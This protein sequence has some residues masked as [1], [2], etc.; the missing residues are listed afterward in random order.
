[1]GGITIL[2]RNQAVQT[3][4]AQKVAA[5][6]SDKLGA[7]VN[8]KKLA[9]DFS[10]NI[11][12][13]DILIRDQTGDTMIFSHLFKTQLSSWD[14]N[15]QLVFFNHSSL[16]EGQ[17]NIVLLKDKEDLN[18]R[19]FLDFFKPSNKKKK[20]NKKDW[21]IN[22]KTANLNQVLFTY[23]NQN[24]PKEPSGT[25]DPQ[26]LEF[27]NINGLGK[28]LWLIADSIHFIA[29]DL[30]TVEKSGLKIQSFNAI[31][32]IHNKGMD[33]DELLC[34]TECSILQ[35]ELHFRYPGYKLLSD[36]ISNTEWK[37]KLRNTSICLKE[38][39]IFS[40]F[41]KNNTETLNLNSNISGT[42]DNLNLTKF[43]GTI[44]TNT[45]IKGDFSFKGLPKIYQSEQDFNIKEL[46][47]NGSD[48]SAIIGSA[49][50]KTLFDLGQIKYAGKFNGRFLN[51]T[52]SGLFET[53]H[54]NIDIKSLSMDIENGLETGT[55]AGD[56]KTEGFNLNAIVPDKG[57]GII[58]FTGN[59]NGT[60]ITSDIVLEV[61]GNIDKLEYKKGSYQN[62]KVNG[63]ASSKSF[64]G[65]VLSDDPNLNLN[66]DGELG[67]G[68]DNPNW[69]FKTKLQGLDL[70][71]LG[72]GYLGQKVWGLADV[73][74]LGKDIKTLT[75]DILLE[76][77]QIL[78]KGKYYNYKSIAI[79]KT[80]LKDGGSKLE[81]Y[82]DLAEAEIKGNIDITKIGDIIQHNLHQIFPDRFE[83]VP[84]SRDA[85]FSF[86]TDIKKPAFFESFIGEKISTNGITASGTFIES[87]G[88]LLLKTN[89]FTLNYNDININN[90]SIDINKLSPKS[91]EYGIN[92]YDISQAGKMIIKSAEI[93]G[94]AQNGKTSL[95][96]RIV[97]KTGANQVELMGAATLLN[98][99]IPIIINKMKVQIAEKSW[100]LYDM[101]H[102]YYARNRVYSHDLF[103]EGDDNYLEIS[104]FFGS[105]PADTGIIDFSN[106]GP[107][108]FKPFVADQAIL[109]STNFRLS[110]RLLIQSA[111]GNPQIFGETYAK[112]ISYLGTNYGD[113]RID[114]DDAIA[115]NEI[116]LIA[117]GTKGLLE[118]L[119][120]SGTINPS[121]VEGSMF[122]LSLAIPKRTP[123]S[124]IQPILKGI[125]T[126]DSGHISGW[127]KLRGNPNKPVITGNFYLD[128]TTILVDYLNTRF[129]FEGDFFVNQNGFFSTDR[130][131]L[132]DEDKTGTAQAELALTFD[133]FKNLKLNLDI[134]K[135]NNLKCLNT[136]R[137][138]N[139]LFF[140][141]G[142]VD[143][144]CRIHGPLSAID[145]EIN[146]KTKAK[147]KLYIPYTETE[148]NT[149][150]GFIEFKKK[151]GQEDLDTKKDKSSINRIAI[152]IESTPET[153]VFFV[154]DEQLGDVIKGRGNGLLRMLYD[155]N[156]NFFLY[157]TYTIEQGE[158]E[159]SLP[160][161]NLLTRKITLD[162]GGQV[163]WTGDPYDAIL[164][165]SGSFTKKLSPAV[166]MPPGSKSYPPITVISKLSLKGALF[167]PDISFDLE[168][169]DLNTSDGGGGLLSSTFARI[170][171]DEDER[172]RQAVWLL[173]F[174]S[175]VPPSNL[176]TA[177]PVAGSISGLGVAGNSLGALASSQ[178]NKIFSQFGLP[179][180]FQLN[181]DNVGR[182]YT[183]ATTTQVYIN[184]E[185]RLSDKVKLDVNYD[186]TVNRASN[187]GVNF[188][189]EFTPENSKW[190]MRIFSRNQNQLS[191]L[192]NINIQTV[193]GYTLGAGFIFQTDFNS[194]RRKR[195]KA[196]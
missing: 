76:D 188:N 27:K 183:T 103:L 173:L 156:S 116:A 131:T 5:Y 175:F 48:I 192:D 43:T 167:K 8:I 193:S 60:N 134:T 125:V 64:I 46:E 86:T 118:G 102:L 135:A 151:P 139:D 67:Y 12:A 160:G 97:D 106:V 113:L 144:T 186:N 30:S 73:D 165:M 68:Q 98:D 20:L 120:I 154:I 178:A 180:Q 155:E 174:G 52:T 141:L 170:R 54:G 147:S 62:I 28:D 66:F 87:Q 85:N 182:T 32:N 169:P 6:L 44:G 184:S 140:G 117:N 162:K 122:R 94:Q 130:I 110:G 150:A 25:I 152:E 29:Q 9:I 16:S 10:R 123:I 55:M 176:S 50:P 191:S 164:N 4:I 38:L 37:G 137:N 78:R 59:L 99:S 142:Y 18:I 133:N 56:F 39:K 45:K 168:S 179:T 88:V 17:V 105:S 157:G 136:Q 101:A 112:D 21:S 93:N 24:A 40:D 70:E 49:M 22:F 138:D 126:I 34:K 53:S 15:N 194:Y 81:M 79:S 100:D 33:F 190:R 153:E 124:I 115:S 114:F 58:A 107:D 63:I 2:L 195:K 146:L 13:E 89:P 41:F 127:A 36:F 95:S 71:S 158:Y 111:M 148:V 149:I 72:L 26:H 57:I 177:S 143:G 23:N 47:T 185:T 3:K 172:M 166:L 119:M 92:A 121:E 14:I 171:A 1:M 19:F 82:G 84:T 51:F 196:Q 128:T 161:I 69:I 132:I 42:F 90:L 77:V 80:A 65:E 181:F 108:F 104:G 159:F 189:L 96:G 187:G 61:D 35:N 91:A 75:G 163:T 74:V 109:D 31:S 129:T 145:M 11:L 7:E 83:N